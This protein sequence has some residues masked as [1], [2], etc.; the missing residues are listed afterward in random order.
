MLV[1]EFY[2]R[3]EQLGTGTKT[4]IID[5]TW[6]G[7]L[8]LFEIYKRVLRIDAQERALDEEKEDLLKI[9][10]EYLESLPKPRLD[11]RT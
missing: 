2:D 1:R 6:H 8:T 5:S 4:A 3:F 10:E 11:Y 9:A 7:E